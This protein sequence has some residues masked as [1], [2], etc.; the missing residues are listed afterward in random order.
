MSMVLD[1]LFVLWREGDVVPPL[2]DEMNEDD[3]TY[4]S[5]KAC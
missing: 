4:T 3:S 2:F 5:T 1:C